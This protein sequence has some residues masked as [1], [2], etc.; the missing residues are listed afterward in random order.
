MKLPAVAITG[1]FASGIALGLHPAIAIHPASKQLLLA[2]FLAAAV[3]VMNR[4]LMFR[5]MP[6]PKE[7]TSISA[8]AKTK[9]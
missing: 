3:L 9:S 1:A 2:S 8:S 7:S 5:S 4:D 6:R